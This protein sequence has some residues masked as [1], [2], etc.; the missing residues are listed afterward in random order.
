MNY[1]GERDPEMHQ[2]KKVN[3]WHFCMRAYIGV[4]ADS[5]YRGV[6]KREKIQAQ[7]PYL[8]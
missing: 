6:H 4:D 3:Q 2:A 7:H 8:D 5:C 1:K